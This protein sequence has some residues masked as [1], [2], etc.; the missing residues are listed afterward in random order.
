MLS[1]SMTYPSLHIIYQCINDQFKS[2]NQ[3]I[4]TSNFFKESFL[5]T[6]FYRRIRRFFAGGKIGLPFLPSLPLR[7]TLAVSTTAVLTT[8][9][10]PSPAASDNRF[11]DSETV[12][13]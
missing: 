10:A 13:K 8:A 12:N 2:I 7:L 1:Q 6:I 11:G 9:V 5:V 3:S 4:S